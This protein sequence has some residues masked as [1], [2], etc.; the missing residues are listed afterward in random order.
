MHRD[1]DSGII[2]RAGSTDDFWLGV[3]AALDSPENR[4]AWIKGTVLS[5]GVTIRLAEALSQTRTDYE[6]AGHH[7]ADLR[8]D[9]DAGRFGSASTAGSTTERRVST[10]SGGDSA[11]ISSI[12]T[13][14]Y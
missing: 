3:L 2:D 7:R 13:T 1:W 4:A 5:I 12:M 10:R 6:S 14:R 11:G 8:L 9:G